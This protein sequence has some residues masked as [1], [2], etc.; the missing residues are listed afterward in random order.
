MPKK[1]EE[2]NTKGTK[3]ATKTSTSKKTTSTKNAVKTT[4]VEK[5]VKTPEVK[6]E[7][8]NV[9]TVKKENKK[10][11][12]ENSL[13]NNTPFV[14]SVCV[15][16][17]LV[18]ILIFVACTKRVPVTSEGQEIVATLDGKTITAD[19]LYLSLKDAGGKDQLLN[20]IDEYIAEKEVT[21]TEKDEEYVQEVVDY[22]LEYAEY[23]ETDLETFLTNYVG[24]SGIS[25]EEEFAEFVLKDYKK[26]LA[27]T[28]FIS[29][30]ASEEDLET[31][32]NENYSD[33]LTVKHILIEIDSEAEDKEA[34]DEEAYNK[35]VKLIKKL[36]DTKE[37]DLD[38]KFEELAEKNSDDTGTYSNGGLVENFTKS[39]VEEEFYEAS[40][41]L[42]DGEYTEEP[43]KT[44]YGYHIILKVSSTEA[45][46]YEDV[47]DEVKRGWAEKQLNA[48]SNLYTLKWDELRNSYNLSIKDDFMKEAYKNSIKNVEETKTEE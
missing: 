48:D 12:K 3:K 25:T 36:N 4:K 8:I 21:V 35:A 44:S 6:V 26:T 22:Y 27:V 31:Y 28:N 32:Y 15:I 38:K 24:L 42:K 5:V 46:K 23:Y 34:A 11:N 14:V 9:A 1:T 17:L 19:E 33:Y 18:A 20:I 30:K 43:I 16:I 41:N 29:E 45:D 13:M 39:E 2:K 37:K 10:G 47:V 7:E 40:Y